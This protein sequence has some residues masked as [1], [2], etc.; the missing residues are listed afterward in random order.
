MREEKRYNG[1][2]GAVLLLGKDTK[3]KVRNT[4]ASYRHGN[5]ID[6]IEGGHEPHM[7][8]YHS[9]FK[10]LPSGVVD[11]LLKNLAESLPV[12]LSFTELS[13]FGGKFLFLNIQK[14]DQLQKI[15]EYSLECLSAYF[16]KEGKQQSSHENITLS[17]GE[18]SNVERYGHPLVLEYWQPHITIGYFPDG[19]Q[20]ISIEKTFEGESISVAFV[21]IGEAGSIEQII[22]KT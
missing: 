16:D 6:L 22:Q 10:N 1:Q 8:I 21:K 18:H 12:R 5:V 13:S 2:Y 4:A 9:K 20:N 7:T 15:H 11:E 19:V 14:S 3:N 17:S